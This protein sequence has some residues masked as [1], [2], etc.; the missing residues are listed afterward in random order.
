VYAWSR[1]SKSELYAEP[2]CEPDFKEGGALFLPQMYAYEF[3]WW[4][5]LG[6]LSSIGFGTGLHSG[7]MF[8][9]HVGLGGR[10][11]QDRPRQGDGRLYT[12]SR[13]AVTWPW[14]WPP[15]S[16]FTAWPHQCLRPRACVCAQPL[17]LASPVTRPSCSGGAP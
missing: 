13:V 15:V 9:P 14:L 8:L 6:I 5:V 7:I 12:V 11:H 4:L 17:G 16:V 1:Y 3:F 10:R 2:T